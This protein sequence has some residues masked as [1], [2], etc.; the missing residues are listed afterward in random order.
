MK[1]NQAQL[2]Q[3]FPS[4]S[5]SQLLHFLSGRKTQQT[6]IVL[7]FKPSDQ[8]RNNF[9]M[10][11]NFSRALNICCSSALSLTFVQFVQNVISFL[12]LK[13]YDIYKVHCKANNTSLMP[14]NSLRLRPFQETPVRSPHTQVRSLPSWWSYTLCPYSQHYTSTLFYTSV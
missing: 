5:T 11:L 12:L 9:K 8:G 7:A 3:R 6:H 10:K 2:C 14:T 13:T 4:T 1:I